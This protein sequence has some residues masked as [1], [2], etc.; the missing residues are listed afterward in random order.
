MRPPARRLLLQAAGGAGGARLLLAVLEPG[1]GTGSSAWRAVNYRGRPVSLLAGPAAVLAA[2]GA[3][4]VGAAP[5]R[6]RLAAG[7]AAIGAAGAGRYD[8]RYGAGP[9]RGLAGHLDALAR[10]EVS[11]GI[12]KVLGI[13]ASGLAAGALVRRRVVDSVLVGAVVA[14]CANLVNLLDLRPGR[15]LKVVIVASLAVVAQRGSGAE[16]LAGPSGAAAALLPAD[17]AERTML[18]DTGANGL[19][20][21]VGVGLVLGASRRRLVALL[22]GLGAFTAASEVVS[23]SSVIDRVPPLRWLDR[24]GRPRPSG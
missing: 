15:A 7:V 16:L 13:G 10:G 3:A 6:C 24:L 14:A 12:V 23:F 2:A 22:L 1:F 9:V 5:A 19:G 20:A 17:L 11:T 8:D 18:G 4:A 21:L